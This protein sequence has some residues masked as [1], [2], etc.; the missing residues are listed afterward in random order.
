[1]LDTEDAEDIDTEVWRIPMLRS[2]VQRERDADAEGGDADTRMRRDANTRREGMPRLRIVVRS[3]QGGGY[4]GNAMPMPR[5]SDAD[6]EA[7]CY[8]VM[9]PITQQQ[10][11]WLANR[12]ERQVWKLFQ[13]ESVVG[14]TSNL[15]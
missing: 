14:R 8:Q 4:Q 13:D 11:V 7:E 2:V 1:M 6:A 12:C 9:K 15:L 5:E 10:L 3:E